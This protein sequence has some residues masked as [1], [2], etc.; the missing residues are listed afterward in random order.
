MKHLLIAI[1][2]V[3]FVYVPLA[4]A[5]PIE[6]DTCDMMNTVGVRLTGLAGKVTVN[7]GQTL[8]AVLENTDFL[9]RSGMT[10][11]KKGDAIK[12]TYMG[13]NNW[14]FVHVPSGQQLLHEI[15][16]NPANKKPLVLEPGF[17]IQ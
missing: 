14:K 6:I 1:A 8:N 12:A 5:I 3:M 11:L 10:G 17:N 4:S 15:K 13:N 16:I 9:T 7:E 2:L